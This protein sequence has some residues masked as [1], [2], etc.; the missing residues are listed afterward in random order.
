MGRLKKG[1]MGINWK[2]C[3]VKATYSIHTELAQLIG[4]PETSKRTLNKNSFDH[5]G[6]WEVMGS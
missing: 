5:K 2:Y 1:K 4:E 3:S 6:D